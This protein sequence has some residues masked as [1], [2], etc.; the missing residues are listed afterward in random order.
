MLVIFPWGSLWI[1]ALLAVGW[2]L[3]DSTV[4][5]LAGLATLPALCHC[6]AGPDVVLPVS[7]VMLLLTLVKRLEGNRRLLPSSGPERRRV[8]LRRLILDR[9]IRS[10]TD[11]IGRTPD[12]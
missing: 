2:R 10:H 6:V 11:W 12:D 7:A 8:M 1:L 5:A 3:G 9:D 4:W